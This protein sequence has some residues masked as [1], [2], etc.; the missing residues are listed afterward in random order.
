MTMHVIRKDDSVTHSVHCMSCVFFSA[1]VFCMLC[2]L[3]YRLIALE[4]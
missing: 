1:V 4:A 2:F 3:M